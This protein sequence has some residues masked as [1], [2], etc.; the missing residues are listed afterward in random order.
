MNEF[1]SLLT[2]PQYYLPFILWSLFWKGLALWTSAGKKQLLWFVL[3]LVVNTFGLLEIAYF[4]FLKRWDLDNG[5][6]LSY[7]EKKFKKN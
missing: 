2:Q 5:R 6:V 4:F 7:L 1:G 3:L